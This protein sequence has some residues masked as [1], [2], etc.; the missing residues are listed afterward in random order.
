MSKRCLSG[1]LPYIL[2]L[3]VSCIFGCSSSDS[4]SVEVSGAESPL[5]AVRPAVEKIL[6]MPVQLKIHESRNNHEWT[7]L[8][9][10]PLTADGSVIDYSVTSF[11][12]DVREGYFDDWLCA[13]VQKNADGKWHLVALDVGATDAPFV[14]WPER[15]GVPE[16][17][18]IPE[19]D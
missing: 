12:E 4:G 1:L 16:K 19:S 17:L 15:Y 8:T 7:F 10:T 2:L 9:A 14:D 18:V 11:A 5:E 13:L 3:F 6:G